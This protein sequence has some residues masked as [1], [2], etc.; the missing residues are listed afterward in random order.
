MW[1][2]LAIAAIFVCGFLAPR[3]VKRGA[4]NQGM[5]HEIAPGDARATARFE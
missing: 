3:V 4:L 5:N 1:S 2:V